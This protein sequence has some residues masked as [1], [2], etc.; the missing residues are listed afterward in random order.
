MWGAGAPARAVLLGGI[1][2]YRVT[3]SP[4]LGSQCRFY[5]SCSR[6]AEEAIATRGAVV[7]SALAVWR[8]VRCNPFGKGGVEHLGPHL[9]MTGSYI[10]L[11]RTAARRQRPR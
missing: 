9:D 10:R 4:L 5:P 11:S 1:R 7:G 8:I 6:Y 2:L 3:L